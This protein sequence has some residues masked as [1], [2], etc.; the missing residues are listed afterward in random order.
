MVSNEKRWKLLLF[1]CLGLAIGSAFCMKWMESDL[2]VDGKSFTI[3]GLELFYG[4]QE[5]KAVLSG[6]DEKVRTILLYHL[7]FDFVFMAGIFPFIASLC[8]LASYKTANRAVRKIL[9]IIGNLQLLAWVLD[10]IENWR[11]ID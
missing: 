7:S 4:S 11:L 6:L 2:E 1:S 10:I 3:I 8:I 5:M 9:V